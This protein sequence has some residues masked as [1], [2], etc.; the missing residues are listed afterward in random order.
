MR[1]GV[2]FRLEPYKRGVGFRA[3]VSGGALYRA[4][5]LI[6]NGVWSGTCT[7]PV[8][9]DCKHD[10]AT[11]LAGLQMASATGPAQVK[12]TTGE[13]D[14]F[15]ERVAAKLGRELT[16]PEQQLAGL[17]DE[18]FT[19]FGH[20]HV[21]PAS[22]LEPICG[23]H[24]ESWNRN[25]VEVW[26]QTPESPWQAWLYIAAYLRRN[27]L[28]CRPLLL[29][30]TDWQEVD[31]LVQSWERQAHVERWREW[32]QQAAPQR[33]GR[34][35]RP[36]ELRVRLTVEGAQLESRKDVIAE[37]TPLKE[38]TFTQL[39]SEAYAGRLPFD[40]GSLPIWHAFHTGYGSQP[41]RKFEEP[42]CARILNTLLRQPESASR[43]VGPR[44]LPLL[45]AEERLTWQVKSA[46]DL[47]G[48]YQ[49]ALLRKNGEPLPSPLTIIE[50]EPS[51]YVSEEGIFQGPPLGALDITAGPVKIPAQALESSDGVALLDRLRIPPPPRLA[52]RIR[53]VRMRTVFH[54]SLEPEKMGS[55]EWL[56]VSARAESGPGV[57]EQTFNRE[58][59]QRAPGQTVGEDEIVRMD[60]AAME[61]V[62]GL[63]EALRLTWNQY[64][65]HWQ[66]QVGKPFPQ[67]F[68]E[69]L[70]LM[71]EEIELELDP[72]LA[73][74]RGAPV[75]AGVKLEVEE[76]DIDWFD[77][78]VALDVEDTTLTK[79][80]IKMLLDARGGF[81]RLGAKGWRRLTFEMSAEDEAQLADLGLSAREFSSEPQRLHALQLAGKSAARR[82]LSAE[83]AAAMER[84]AIEIQTRVAPP[85]PAELLAELRPYQR[86]R[87]SL[88]RLSHREPLRRHPG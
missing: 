28:P 78:K 20:A 73:S 83:H 51:L 17:V 56:V 27:G 74:L 62:P 13:D 45:R 46:D 49:L 41:F 18:L 36:I 77:L 82:L 60:R 33:S 25:V 31:A 16:E 6:E 22:R 54:C 40:A 70:D 47:Q 21:L 68:T 14:T 88:P 29:E 53:D 19:Q 66:R 52:A 43:V 12:A 85:V 26:P 63:I 3:S 1:D 11:L 15:V 34:E 65:L 50:G 57:V 72:L 38:S 35:T 42:D 67:Q 87:L 44:G 4:K 79:K 9:R 69:W 2:V 55:R 59:W 61:A 32:L 81:V 37:F 24:G 76:A 84:R 58:G 80:E 23:Q 8:R 86:R 39:V 5:V 30:V 75:K 48:D 7:C 10:V 64:D 71:P